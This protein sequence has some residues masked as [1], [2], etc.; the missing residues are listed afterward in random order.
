MYWSWTLLQQ[1]CRPSAAL[2]DEAIY[3]PANVKKRVYI[4]DEVHML[5]TP[6]FNALLKI[7]EEPPST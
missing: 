5:S 3:A 6:A 4:V 1:R 7:L 2:R